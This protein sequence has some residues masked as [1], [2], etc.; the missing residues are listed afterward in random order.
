MTIDVARFETMLRERRDHLNGKLHRY[1]ES[2]DREPPKDWEDRA[3]EREND[4]VIEGLGNSGLL[5]LRQIDEA[6]RR[7][8]DGSYG[9]CLKCGEDISDERLAVVPQAG[10]CRNCM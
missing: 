9:I 6:L 8:A 2:L 3:T 4:E 5:E 10:L 7:I 1:E